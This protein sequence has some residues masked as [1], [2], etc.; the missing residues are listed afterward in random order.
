MLVD[1]NN[2]F[3]EKEL[4]T[5][6]PS[7]VDEG[8]MNDGGL[9]VFPFAKSTEILYLNQ[10]LFDRFSEATGVPLESLSTFEGIADASMK[11]YEWTDSLT[12]DITND[13]KAFYAA[14]SWL[15]LAQAAM[16]QQG[17]ELFVDEKLNLFSPAYEKIWNICYLPSTTGG[18]AIYDGYSSDL[19]KTGDLVCSTGSS[20]GI[21][22]YGDTITYADNTV[23]QVEYT[24]LPFPTMEGGRKY[25]L[26]RGNGLFVAKSDSSKEYAA[27]IFLKWFTKPEQ[28][29]RFI[30]STGYLPVTT[31]AFGE[32][33]EQEIT[34]M[35]N[36]R[37]KQM[38][39]AVTQMYEEY[40]FF[41][42]PL[43]DSFDAMGKTYE[44]DYKK[45]LQESTDT[46]QNCLE[47]FRN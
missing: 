6:V 5:Y 30:S 16:K 4:N 3:T 25:A 26:Q 21:L 40:E 43:F 7:F 14:D 1:L 2:Y 10:T 38:L 37:I 13:G 19:S 27:S 11:Y 32:L 47:D 39:T 29:M 9:Y 33:M 31:E 36:P 20:A 22:F 35:E 45:L 15:N 44:A 12:P 24:I 42:A 34:S 46:A 28:N 23:E 17:D 8:R 18:F 41:V